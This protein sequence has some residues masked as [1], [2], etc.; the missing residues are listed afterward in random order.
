MNGVIFMGYAICRIEK[1]NSSYEMQSRYKH[2]FREYDVS[3]VNG[4]LSHLNREIKGLNGKTYIESSDEELIRMRMNGYS[5][6]R[7]RKDAVRGLEVILS[8][9]YDDKDSISLDR[10]INK[11]VEWLEEKFNPKDHQI[12]IKDSDGS[13][14]IVASDNVKS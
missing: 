4:E 5:G 7:E 11:N 6:K 14:H 1:I 10:W 2:N 9:S 8:Y 13:E 12:L 3:H